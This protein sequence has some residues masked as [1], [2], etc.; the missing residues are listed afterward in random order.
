[1]TRARRSVRI[2]LVVLAAVAGSPWLFAQDA[3]LR[4][5]WTKGEEQ[6]YR[7]TTQTE[8]VMSGVPGMGD[9]NIASTMVQVHKMTVEDVAADGT[10]TLRY[11]YE[12]FK[13]TMAIPMAGEMTYDSTAPP[14]EGNPVTD[15]LKPLG[16]MAGQP[17]TIVVSPLGKI[18]KIAGLSPILEKAKSGMAAG[19]GG[20]LGAG[21]L[22]SVLSEE[23]QRSSIEQGFAQLSGNP[24]KV[25]ETWKLVFKIPSPF[26][27]QAMSLQS[28]L[29]EATAATARIV[30]AGTLKP[31]GAPGTLGPM[32]VTMGDGTSNGE[33][34]FDLKQGRLR[35]MTTVS[36]LPLTLAM[37]APDG[38]TINLQA[39]QKTTTTVELIDK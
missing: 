36:S 26:G 17:F 20:A 6:R 24:A 29:Q 22:S 14:A 25:G 1:M 38:T 31:E 39:A 34:T 12:S 15:S 2:L 5:R 11:V 18:A 23:S 9:M 35:K 21:D 33:A 8:M 28:T 13:M 7:T 3:T 27:V 37:A 19:A 10:A 16:A 32:T 30:T 4:Y